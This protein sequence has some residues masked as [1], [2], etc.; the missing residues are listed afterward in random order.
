MI[1]SFGTVH[2]EE[3]ITAPHAV[4]VANKAILDF[5]GDFL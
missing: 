2:Y 5:R 4:L 3:K 1:D